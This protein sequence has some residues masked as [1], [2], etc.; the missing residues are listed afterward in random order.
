MY[1]CLGGGRHLNCKPLWFSVLLAQRK[2]SYRLVETFKIAYTRNSSYEYTGLYRTINYTA[3]NMM[4]FYMLTNRILLYKHTLKVIFGTRLWKRIIFMLVMCFCFVDIMSS[5]E[6]E[7]PLPNTRWL[8]HAMMI[9]IC[10]LRRLN[11]SMALRLHIVVCAL[12]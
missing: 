10:T 2:I 11:K 9:L 5:S 4:T 3:Y 8:F 1:V 6:N 7:F 12:Y